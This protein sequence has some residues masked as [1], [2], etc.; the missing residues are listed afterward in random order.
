MKASFLEQA[1]WIG[2][3]RREELANRAKVEEVIDFLESQ[4]IR[5]TPVGRV[6]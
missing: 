3:A 4:H 2:P 1:L 6:A 5:K